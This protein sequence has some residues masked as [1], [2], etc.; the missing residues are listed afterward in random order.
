MFFKGGVTAIPSWGK[1]WLA[2]LNVYSWDGMH[3]LTPEL[4]YVWTSKTFENKSIFI[5]NFVFVNI[6]AFQNIFSRKLNVLDCSV[7]AEPFRGRP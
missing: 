6:E 2:V 1:F 3:S 5:L 7:L 4:W